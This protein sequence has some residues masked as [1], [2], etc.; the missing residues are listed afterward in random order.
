[1]GQSSS[2]ET[3]EKFD[4]LAKKDLGLYQ[5]IINSMDEF[6]AVVGSTG[7]I[8]SINDKALKFLGFDETNKKKLTKKKG[9]KFLFKKYPNLKNS[10]QPHLGISSKFALLKI[11]QR[12]I[13]SKKEEFL[14]C[15]P[16]K[17]MEEKWIKFEA[18][19]MRYANEIAI[20]LVGKNTQNPLNG[21]ERSTS[22]KRFL[23]IERQTS[24]C[25]N[26]KV[27]LTDTISSSTEY[28]SKKIFECAENTKKAKYNLFCSLQ[29]S[30]NKNIRTSRVSFF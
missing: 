26:E 23:E 18:I 27:P 30:P 9:Y 20:Q 25:L 21:E 1:M 14:W 4:T 3:Q 24:K 28:R 10:Y 22:S 2:I 11:I 7:R 16:F 15:V 12:L 5:K 29:D 13:S 17:N 8:L 19:P 6:V